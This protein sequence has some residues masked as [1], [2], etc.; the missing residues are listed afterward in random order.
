MRIAR[1]DTVERKVMT[2]IDNGTQ[3][4]PAEIK[5]SVAELEDEAITIIREVAA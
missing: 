2:M 3:A 5:Q 4:T 1:N